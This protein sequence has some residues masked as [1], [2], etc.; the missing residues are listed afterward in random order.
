MYHTKLNIEI[1]FA[2]HNDFV[3]SVCFSPDGKYLASGSLDMSII[4]WE[5]DTKKEIFREYHKNSVYEVVFSPDG[6]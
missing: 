6:K 4:I 2:Q 1:E 3:T 5:L